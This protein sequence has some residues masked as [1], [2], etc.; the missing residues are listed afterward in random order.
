MPARESGPGLELPRGR[1]ARQEQE[2]E[3]EQPRSLLRREA[4]QREVLRE[5]RVRP[6]VLK[7]GERQLPRQPEL[8]VRL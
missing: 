4:R 3:Q 6:A 8:Q 5:P 1:E 2:Q 7:S